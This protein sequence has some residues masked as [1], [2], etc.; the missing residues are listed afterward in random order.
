MQPPQVAAAVP[1]FAKFCCAYCTQAPCA[2]QQPLAQFVVVHPPSIPEPPP[3][4]PPIAL[5]PPLPP[6]P[7]APPRRHW[8]PASP[9]RHDWFDE[10]AWQVMPFEPHAVATS[11]LAHE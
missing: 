1:H 6:P 5:P 7:P 8:K 4:P 3:E 10:Q 11:P 2:V 9:P